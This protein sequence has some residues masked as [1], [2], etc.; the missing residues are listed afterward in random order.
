MKSLKI[1]DLSC[2]L[3]SE[4]TILK[5]INRA[6]NIE[7]L[8]INI[9]GQVGDGVYYRLRT[10]Q[11][12]KKLSLNH[13]KLASGTQLDFVKKN[14]SKF[15]GHLPILNLS[16]ISIYELPCYFRDAFTDSDKCDNLLSLKF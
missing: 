2:C 13:Y 10:L 8:R 9:S 1:L 5:F 7:E 16:H 15:R 4:D 14:I 3:L 6:F 12:L 11:N